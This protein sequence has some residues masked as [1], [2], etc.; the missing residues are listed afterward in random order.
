MPKSCFFISRI[1]EAGSSER[2]FSD[3]LLRYIVTP[4]LEKCG[5]EKPV[6]ADHITEPGV[7]TTQVF[8]HLWNDD[9]VIADLTG[10]NPNVFYELAV[11]H[12][13]RKPFVHLIQEGNKIPFDIAPNRTIYFGFDIAAALVAQ[14][15]LEMMVNVGATDSKT[16]Q[17][18]L[19]AAIDFSDVEVGKNPVADAIL[20]TLSV[21]QG[22]R[23]AILRLSSQRTYAEPPPLLAYMRKKGGEY[24]IKF[25]GGQYVDSDWSLI[26][27]RDLERLLLSHADEPDVARALKRV[28]QGHVAVLNL[29]IPSVKQ[30]DADPKLQETANRFWSMIR[31]RPELKMLYV[32][33]VAN[34]SPDGRL[35]LKGTTQEH[36]LMP[37]QM[38]RMMSDEKE[39]VAFLDEWNRVEIE[40]HPNE[41]PELRRSIERKLGS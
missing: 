33:G 5:Y 3:K 32:R 37:A 26:P 31:S 24:E 35:W 30:P 18:P 41:E 19:S 21:V 27:Q 7:I 15:A 11:R 12:V 34:N 29:R 13:R 14:N 2:A 6:R 1:G 40:E 39:L 9:L 28:E 20:E 25:D 4:V 38:E 17:T 8:Q 16:V 10:G 23:G 22:L 36:N